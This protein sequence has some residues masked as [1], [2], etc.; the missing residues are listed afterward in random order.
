MLF[1]IL[2]L[3]AAGE[4]IRPL[5]PFV[6]LAQARIHFCKAITFLLTFSGFQP[7]LE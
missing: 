1:L 5:S 4:A 7:S 2:L 6:I 3:R